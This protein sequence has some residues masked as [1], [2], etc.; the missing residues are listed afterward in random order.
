MFRTKGGQKRGGDKKNLK[1][2][3]KQE[4]LGLNNLRP[5]NCVFGVVFIFEVIFLFLRLLNGVGVSVSEIKL[6]SAILGQLA[7]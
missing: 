5:Y 7:N 3:G 4:W 6:Y 1:E 2:W